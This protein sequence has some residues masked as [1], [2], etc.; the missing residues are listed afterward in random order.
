MQRADKALAEAE[1]RRTRGGSTQYMG[2]TRD[3][4]ATATQQVKEVRAKYG[5]ALKAIS[6]QIEE[7]QVRLKEAAASV[8][9]ANA[10]DAEAQQQAAEDKRKAEEDA[11]A[12]AKEQTEQSEKRVQIEAQRAA[13]ERQIGD[14]AK[15]DQDKAIIANSDERIKAS[16]DKLAAL[17]K[18]DDEKQE[19]ERARRQEDF[20]ERR[21]KRLQAK[22]KK[23]GRMSSFEEDILAGGAAKAELAG[24]EEAR[25]VAMQNLAEDEKRN[26][27]EHRQK[28]LTSLADLNKNLDGLPKL[29]IAS[30]Q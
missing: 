6:D 8:A 11:L 28:L 18:T 17:A 10:K 4:V 26:A 13:L 9:E 12:L 24:A 1:A 22:K 14:E 30:G 15:A 21:L 16:R 23:G 25:Q 27:A 7:N 19:A 5:D 2:A 20:D 29:L 3:A